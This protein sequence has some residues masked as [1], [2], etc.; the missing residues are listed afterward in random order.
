MQEFDIRKYRTTLKLVFLKAAHTIFPDDVVLIDNS[1]NNGAY[2]EIET[3]K[4]SLTDEDIEKIDLEMKKIIKANYPIKLICDDNEILKKKGHTIDRMDIRKLLKY[5][6]W[7]GMME[8][9]IDGYVDY[10]YMK[11]YPNTGD[12]S[13]YEISRYNGGFI[14]KYPFKEDL[15]LPEKIDTPKLAKVFADCSRWN[16]ILGVEDIGDLNEKVVNKE[17]AELIRVNEALHHK[18]IAN[19]AENISSNPNIKL[20][21]IAGPSSSGKTTFS[22]RLYTHLRANGIKPIVIGLDNY[23]IGRKNVPLDEDGNKDFETIEA[24]DLKLL[25]RNLKD[26]IDGKE[27][28]IPIYNF[29]TGEREK[30]Y[31]RMKMA[32]ENGVIIIEGIHG[33]NERLTADIPRENKYKIYISC[34]T[35]LNIDKHSR[36]STSD[37]REIRRLVRDSLSRDEDGEGTLAMWNSVR[38]GEE[39]Y[40]FPYQ[41]EADALFNSNLV[42]ELGV[43]KSY[44]LRELIKIAPSSPYYEEA[45]RIIKFLYCFVDIDPTLIPGD[46]ILKEFIGNSIFY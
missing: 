42:Y 20:V 10:V 41:E 14:L 6:I 22:N 7:T 23:Y 28:D 19:I 38:K 33:L 13:V 26:L 35:Q 5:T 3:L 24:L 29:I 8:Y 9:E 1:L 34:L 4:R 44:A 11:P 30:E 46:S 18:K 2:G 45:K 43:L 40:I 17:I 25:N 39:K 15:K 27:A 21:T 37:V 16:K 31:N 12:I 32:E 36:I